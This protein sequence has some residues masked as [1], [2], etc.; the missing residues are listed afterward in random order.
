MLVVGGERPSPRSEASVSLRFLKMETYMD[1]MVAHGGRVGLG[2]SHP[3][4]RNKEVY[5]SRGG[6]QPP[7]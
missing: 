5:V 4:L 2:E 1:L 7:P 3:L 6:N